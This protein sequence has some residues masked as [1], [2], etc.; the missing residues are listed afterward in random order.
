MLVWLCFCLFVFA[1]LF[2]CCLFLFVFFVSIFVPLT[3]FNL[4]SKARP[5]ISP[6][7]G[8]RQQLAMWHHMQYSLTGVLFVFFSAMYSSLLFSCSSFPTCIPPFFTCISP[9]YVA[10]L[11]FLLSLGDTQAHRV[12]RAQCFG[13]QVKCTGALDPITASTS[14][15]FAPDPAFPNKHEEK[16][17]LAFL[18]FKLFVLSCCC[19]YVCC[20]VSSFFLLFLL[21][22]FY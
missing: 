2:V 10:L 1:C 13:R 9:P 14:L 15:L 12:Y 17:L 5:Q 21:F 19:F 18:F 8:F 4:V 3:A 11:F 22:S 7:Q 6:N 20:S 16:V